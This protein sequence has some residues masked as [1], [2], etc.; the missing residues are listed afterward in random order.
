MYLTKKSTTEQI[1]SSTAALPLAKCYGIFNDCWWSELCFYH[2][3]WSPL[4]TCA[5]LAGLMSTEHAYL[6]QHFDVPSSKYPILNH[7]GKPSH[8]Q[9]LKKWSYPIYRW[10]TSWPCDAWQQCD[11]SV[12]WGNCPGWDCTGLVPAVTEPQ[13]CWH[14]NNIWIY[15]SNSQI[16]PWMH[17]DLAGSTQGKKKKE[18][19]RAASKAEGSFLYRSVCPGGTPVGVWALLKCFLQAGWVVRFLSC[20]G[21]V[22]CVYAASFLSAGAFLV[23]DL[24]VPQKPVRLLFPKTFFKF[25]WNCSSGWKRAADNRKA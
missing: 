1:C 14:P 2:H 17:H 19:K 13:W 21:A 15:L 23:S 25:R 22:V 3:Q 20:T 7:L 16:L 9:V 11:L 5:G 6:N 12:R 24:A 10:W 4:A 18:A 8:S